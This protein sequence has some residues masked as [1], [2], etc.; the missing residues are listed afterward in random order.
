M[1]SYQC[2][3]VLSISSVLVIN[4][5][6]NYAE[7]TIFYASAFWKTLKWTWVQYV[8]FLVIFVWFLRIVNDWFFTTASSLILLN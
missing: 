3:S 1:S 7:A 6:L 4:V 5:S 2:N 8:A